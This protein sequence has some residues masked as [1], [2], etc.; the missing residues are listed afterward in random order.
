MFFT[1]SVSLYTSRV[2]LNTLGV[3]DYGTYNLVGG[4]V[5]LFSFFNA[6]MSSATQRFLSFEIG[7]NN[8]IRLKQVFNAT[9]NIHI[10]IGLLILILAET[11]GLWFVNNRLNIPVERMEAVNWVFQFSIFTFL[12]GVIQVPYNAMLIAHEKMNVYAILSIVEVFFKLLIV[13]LLVL[14]PIDKLKTY[15]GLIFVVTFI[16][17]LLYK[18]YCKRKF[19]ESKYQFYY[20]KGLYKTLISYS[21]WNLFGNIASVVRA[22][23]SNVMLN[24]FFGTLLNAAYGI[25]LQIQGAVSL[26]VTNF[27]TAVNP[28]IIKKYAAG[29]LEESKKLIFQSSK[30]SY[31]LMFIIV[32]PIIFNID[33]ILKIWLKTAPEYT[34]LFVCLCLIDLL[35]NCISGPLM[36]G[37][38]ATGNIKWYHI[39]IGSL[40]FLN[41][42][43][44]YF[45]L[46]IY[47]HP[48]IIFKVSISINILSLLFRLFFLK[49]LMGLNVKYFFYEVLLPIIGVS[50]GVVGCMFIITQYIILRN[51]LLNVI[52]LSSC[53]IV[54]SILLIWT[55]SL[56]KL[57]KVYIINLIKTKLK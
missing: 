26:F 31:F 18:I 3:S 1:M 25:T 15:S 27:Q 32:C 17:A 28:Q 44:S 37:V 39:I 5:T 14:S 51:E 56:S 49:K 6:A 13:Y 16:V 36:T 52:F 22:E 29:N 21:G 9:L 41:L 23:G 45:L 33:F 54:I 40:T 48:E 42:P 55:I 11:V 46:K 8:F 43:V 7:Q 20:E 35:I 47:S 57:E 24:I 30:F 38:L 2:V 4:V 53:S 19:D 50:I 10:G 34:A 12:I